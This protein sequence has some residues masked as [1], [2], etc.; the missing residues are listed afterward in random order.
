MEFDVLVFD[1]VLGLDGDD[2]CT[3]DD[4]VASSLLVVDADLDDGITSQEC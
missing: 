3:T 2:V 1:P 4:L